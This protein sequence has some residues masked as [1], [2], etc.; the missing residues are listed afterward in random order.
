[1][2]VTPTHVI[3]DSRRRPIAQVW[4]Y[5]AGGDAPNERIA[6]LLE[7]RGWEPRWFF[8]GRGK[9]KDLFLRCRFTGE[10]YPQTHYEASPNMPAKEMVS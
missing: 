2:S 6:T 9:I 5:S 10:F 7:A 8:I 3:W 4:D 1:M